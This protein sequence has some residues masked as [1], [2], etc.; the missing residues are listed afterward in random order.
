MNFIEN[1]LIISD[2][3]TSV[4]NEAIQ[5]FSR[6]AFRRDPENPRYF[7]TKAE[8]NSVLARL[9]NPESVVIKIEYESDGITPFCY[10]MDYAI[11][12]RAPRRN[13]KV[14]DK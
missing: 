11:I 3:I 10:I 12:N 4:I 13:R 6:P 5:H 8:I 7:Y 14:G 2:A 9:K 1:N